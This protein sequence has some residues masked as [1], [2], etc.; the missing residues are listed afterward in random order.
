MNRKLA[1]ALLVASAFQAQHVLALGVGE[2]TM[3]SALNEPLKAE[4]KLNDVGDLDS[5]QVRVG[6]ASN[7][8]FEDARIEKTFFL[9]DIKFAVEL[10]PSGN[11]VIK[12]SS[13]KRL[14]EPFLDFLL[15]VKWPTGQVL[16]SYTAL[17]DL[18]VY[19]EAEP[20]SVDIAQDKSSQAGEPKAA[21]KP[22][23][24][25]AQA[26]GKEQVATATSA[27]PESTNK[28]EI[29]RTTDHAF[30]QVAEGEYFTQINDTLWEIALE[31]RGESRA[32]VQQV[33]L[34]IQRYNP[35]AFIG[36]NINRLKAGV[37]IELPSADKIQEMNR[38]QAISEVEQQN[39]QWRGAPLD[40]SGSS[41]SYPE[42]TTGGDEGHLRLSSSGSGSADGSDQQAQGAS[43]GASGELAS[44]Q[45]ANARLSDEVGSLN[46]QVDKLERLLELK[47]AELARLQQQLGEQPV[48]SEE[49]KAIEQE[50]QAA[51][52]SLDEQNQ[53]LAEAEEQGEAGAAN[54][55][56]TE[57]PET[58]QE[59]DSASQTEEPA[60]P[61]VADAQEEDVK[62]PSL[63]AKA[64]AN[65]MYL[66]G[67]AIVIIALAA[68][69][70]LR[71]KSKAEQ[72][73]FS[74]FENF[75]FDEPEQN[76]TETDAGDQEQETL[77]V[78]P[79]AG[80]DDDQEIVAVDEIEESEETEV[81]EDQGPVS[82][83]DALNEADV[84]LAYGRFEQAQSL[85]RKALQQNPA[86]VA[87]QAKLLQVCVE[88]RDKQGFQEQY[89]ALQNQGEQAELDNAKELLVA[90]DETST[91]LDDLPQDSMSSDEL[92]LDLPDST[93]FEDNA[94]ITMIRDGIE[95]PSDD[96]ADEPQAQSTDEEELDLGLDLSDEFDELEADDQEV[97]ADEATSLELDDDLS[98][99]LTGIDLDEQ[100]PEPESASDESVDDIDFSDLDLSLD[101]EVLETELE[102]PE[103]EDD[104]GD[105]DISLDF[106]E[107]ADDSAQE[108]PAD[109]D[110]EQEIDLGDFDL[111][112]EDEEPLA[113][114]ADS[115]EEF[116]LGDSLD[117]S[118]EDVAEQPEAVVEAS[119]S[120]SLS[121]L[122]S[123]DFDFL[124][125]ADEIS[126]KLDLAKAYVEM[127]DDEGARDILLEVVKEGNE[128]QKSEAS[129]M[130]DGLE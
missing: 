123:D 111:S 125:D 95:L 64:I 30:S 121:D 19:M 47:S 48:D 63:F 84:Y 24:S 7:D 28:P 51:S 77:E 41:A 109:A 9:N 81:E 124:T 97:D 53:A 5:S 49:A 126:T 31:H 115:A 99:D 129:D 50:L 113:D 76:Q 80:A 33:M 21:K 14:N 118:S 102:T 8:K 96:E 56:E 79:Q 127:G 36:G 4:I 13:H 61:V 66:G 62:E 57:Q 2:M 82:A 26:T 16:R 86:D 119:E 65:P 39:R 11:G 85:L 89:V 69:V 46:S 22:S 90:S 55:Q 94:E 93:D 17:V 72:D 103:A 34:A 116:E 104:L 67:L 1:S 12:L 44:V 73:A 40:A 32:S 105:F 42:A 100:E 54:A 110:L 75:E 91:W 83:E 106:E 15:E 114:V 87:L 10:E 6:L 29:T 128:Q 20:A 107:E 71:R 59:T 108:Q 92:E 35:D 70:L 122:D 101:D 60:K 52:Q 18:P 43:A 112:L 130:L 25:K 37:K 74:E 3:H 23:A 27:Q 38:R 120:S 68:L 45:D 58:E 88:A 117:M 78:E 98:L